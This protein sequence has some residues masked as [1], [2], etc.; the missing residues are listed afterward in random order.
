MYMIVLYYILVKHAHLCNYSGNLKTVYVYYTSLCV[1]AGS[2]E[3]RMMCVYVGL[4]YTI[5]SVSGDP[6][7]VTV[8]KQLVISLYIICAIIRQFCVLTSPAMWWRSVTLQRA[9]R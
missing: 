6:C 4:Y 7:L 3:T 8:G 9:G 1:L 2:V 5:L